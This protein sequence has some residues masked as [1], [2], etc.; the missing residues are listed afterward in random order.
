MFS[1]CHISGVC[2]FLLPSPFLNT[3]IAFNLL[4]RKGGEFPRYPGFSG[5]DTL[6]GVKV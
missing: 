6:Q 5:L 1:N 4:S 3:G 2:P